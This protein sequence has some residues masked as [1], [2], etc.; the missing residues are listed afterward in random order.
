VDKQRRM[1]GNEAEAGTR[2]LAPPR[3]QQGNINQRFIEE[4]KLANKRRQQLIDIAAAPPPMSVATKVL[5][6]RVTE[7]NNF[8]QIAYSVLLIAILAIVAVGTNFINWEFLVYGV[9]AV[10]ARLP[11]TQMF[12]AALISL[13]LI[14]VT[15]IFQRNSLANTFSVMAFYFLLIGLVRASLELRRDS[16]SNKKVTPV[17]RKTSLRGM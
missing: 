12:V 17:K 15:T 13:V 16:K 14:P 11:S 3:K 9:L 1:I 4:Y 6:P 2:R 8:N 5:P 10:L 7:S